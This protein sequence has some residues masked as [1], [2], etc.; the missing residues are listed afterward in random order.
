MEV[1]SKIS[2]RDFPRICNPFP[3]PYWK[4][5]GISYLDIPFKMMDDIECLLHAGRGLLDAMEVGDMPE[6]VLL[7]LALTVTLIAAT[8]GAKFRN[9]LTTR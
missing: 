3:E 5:H 7:V 9:P 6:L 1:F 2:I 8:T 4:P